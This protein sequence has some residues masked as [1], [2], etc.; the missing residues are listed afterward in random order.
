[1]GRKMV[2]QGEP[3]LNIP[4][5][6]ECHGFM[7]TCGLYTSIPVLLGLPRDYLVAQLGA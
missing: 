2:M 4:A 7:L 5:C 3:L 1:M 6:T